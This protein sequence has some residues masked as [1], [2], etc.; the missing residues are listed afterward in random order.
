MFVVFS[1]F[2]IVSCRVV[3]VVEFVV[4]VVVYC[5]FPSIATQ[6]DLGLAEKAAAS[7]AEKSQRQRAFPTCC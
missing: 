1:L 6:P 7:A 3:V 4:V 2:V 5:L